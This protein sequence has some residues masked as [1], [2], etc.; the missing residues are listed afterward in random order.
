[1][2]VPAAADVA[3]AVRD[4]ADAA[5]LDAVER[6][7]DGDTD[8]FASV[9]RR[10]GDGLVRLCAL[11]VGDRPV[12]EELA[13]EALARAYASLGSWRADGR[14]RY[15]LYRIARNC[16]R[17]HLK[18]AARA[19]VRFELAEEPITGR[20]PEGDLAGRQLASALEA[21]IARLPQPYRE[22]FLLFHAENMDYQQIHAITGVSV[23]ALKV[24]VH[25][26]RSMLRRRL[27]DALS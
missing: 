7:L 1:M 2:V 10:H 26:A 11:L 13:Q 3:D 6:T 12:G 16:C 22:A 17:D 21:E 23:G 4:L 9:V 27:G 24:R 19:E 18:A 25:R 14:F 5:D 20:D 8:A 15:W